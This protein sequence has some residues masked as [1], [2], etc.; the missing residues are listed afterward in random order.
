[1]ELC[2]NCGEFAVDEDELVCKACGIVTDGNKFNPE[3]NKFPKVFNQYSTSRYHLKSSKYKKKPENLVYGL[4][5]LKYLVREYSITPDVDNEIRELY[6][7]A[8]SRRKC[9]CKE[10]VGVLAGCCLMQI[11]RK[12]GLFF[13]VQDLCGKLKCS[14]K[15][16]YHILKFVKSFAG[17]ENIESKHTSSEV[18]VNIEIPKHVKDMI[19][20]LLIGIPEE[21]RDILI[22]KTTRLLKLAFSCWILTGRSPK[23]VII[24]AAFLCWKSMHPSRK[25]FPLTKFCS[26][27]S[28]SNS[29]ATKRTSELKAALL[30]LAKNIPSYSEN[31]VNEK[32]VTLHLD[33]ILENSETLRND[34]L[35]NE[36]LEEEINCKEYKSFRVQRI[37]P[38]REIGDNTQCD[39]DMRASDVEI[40]DTEIESYLRSDEQVKLIS[41]LQSLE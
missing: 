21:E 26:M 8:Y 14:K 38:E 32:N 41:S 18:D 40:S 9:K 30:K 5:I 23:G 15:K 25:T 11:Q 31:Y 7:T 12:H 28:L 1:M 10:D 37:R 22:D 19:P 27:Y 4:D 3:S 13:S 35:T 29:Q 17:N 39:L 16:F 36:Y 20:V 34:L 2:E 33:F 6:N 24:A